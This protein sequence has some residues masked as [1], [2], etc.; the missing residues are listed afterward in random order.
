V[1]TAT[2]YSPCNITGFFQVHDKASDPLQVGST[3]AAIA[4][5]K[6]VRTRVSLKR[7]SPSRVAAT[8]NDGRLPQRSV[9]VRVAKRLLE[10][11]GRHWRVDITHTSPF[12]SGFGY[13]TSG[14]GA[15]SVSLALNETM[16]LSLSRLEAAQVAHVSEIECRTGLGTVAS[17][18]SGG[19]TLRT[20]PGAPGV[21]KVSKMDVP[22]SLRLITAS[23]GPISTRSV[24]ERVSLKR[25]VNTC[26]NGL[27]RRFDR[28]A[29]QTSFMM[30]SKEF[31]ECV[32]LMSRRLSQLIFGLDSTGFKSSM[33]MLGESIFCLIPEDVAPTVTTFLQRRGMTPNVSR[34]ANSGAHLI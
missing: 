26:G 6:G 30:L 25:R 34:I 28:R 13:G 16:M 31:S 2:A 24:L 7:A 20:V 14:A 5:E 8:F 21:G 15:L 1:K 17:V 23:F 12:G 33:T 11:D 3:G 27:I 18:F 19:L 32:A 9:S 29:P 22:S 4:L 10:L